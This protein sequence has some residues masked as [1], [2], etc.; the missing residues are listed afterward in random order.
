M[1]LYII[2]LFVRFLDVFHR[3]LPISIPSNFYDLPPPLTTTEQSLLDDYLN[4]ISKMEELEAAGKRYYDKDQHEI[5][6]ADY[7][8]WR[9]TMRPKSKYDLYMIEQRN[10][11][12]NWLTIAVAKG[13]ISIVKELL[14]SKYGLDINIRSWN[15]QGDTILHGA[16]IKGYSDIVI[17]LL[18]NG[19]DI[20]LLSYD[21]QSCLQLTD[22]FKQVKI[23]K[24]LEQWIEKQNKE[25]II[26]EIIKPGVKNE[27]LHNTEQLKPLP[28]SEDE[29]E[30]HDDL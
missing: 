27:Q 19:A 15:G 3:L 28:V 23:R 1:L 20:N 5:P 14:D 29:I 16:I 11:I 24:I 25:E 6:L 7:K 18:N 12:F 13:H 17:L 21:K 9:V 8:K 26:E 30:L 10:K 22:T 4:R 2:Y